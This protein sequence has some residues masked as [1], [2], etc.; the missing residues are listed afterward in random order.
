MEGITHGSSKCAAVSVVEEENQRYQNSLYHY[1][2]RS[3]TRAP[4]GGRLMKADVSHDKHTDTSKNRSRSTV[5]WK[6]TA[7]NTASTSG[8]QET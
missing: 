5:S 3:E 8:S 2:T 7:N 6:H 1:A 4:V